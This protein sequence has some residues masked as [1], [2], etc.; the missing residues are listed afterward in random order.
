MRNVEKE[1][2]S[3]KRNGRMTFILDYCVDHCDKEETQIAWRGLPAENGIPSHSR[4]KFKPGTQRQGT[5]D[6]KSAEEDLKRCLW[7]VTT[8]L[9]FHFKFSLLVFSELTINK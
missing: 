8:L 1:I 5:E 6:T 4:M 9:Q 2:F 3:V 7:N